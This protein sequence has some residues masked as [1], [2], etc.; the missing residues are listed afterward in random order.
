ML[1]QLLPDTTKLSFSEQSITP[2]KVSSVVRFPPNSVTYFQILSE[3][4]TQLGEAIDPA[5]LAS[6]RTGFPEQLTGVPSRR[7]QDNDAIPRIAP[8]WL[9]Y[10]R[11]VGIWQ[12]VRSAAIFAA[13][14]Y[15]NYKYIYLFKF[16]DKNKFIQS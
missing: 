11:Q 1:I 16:N 10:D 5:L 7:D 12:M 6:M 13:R 2:F 8:K 4:T 9:K 3:K 14:I 15:F